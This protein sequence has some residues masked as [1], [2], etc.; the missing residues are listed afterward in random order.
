MTI[1]S[2]F[3]AL[4]ICCFKLICT[5]R[6]I[7]C[8][9]RPQWRHQQ[10]LY[11]TIPNG[12]KIY[13]WYMRKKN[14]SLVFSGSR[15]IQTI[16]STIH[17]ETRQASFPTGT[18]GPRVGIFL[19]PLDINDGFYLSYITT[20]LLS[21]MGR[22]KYFIPKRIIKG[23]IYCTLVTQKYQ[24]RIRVTKWRHITL[25][26]SPNVHRVTIKAMWR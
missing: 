2:L 1:C 17:W 5:A 24:A 3:N 11:C 19:F 20:W 8:K 16:G 6:V 9:H 18:L 10:I 13:N 14:R 12:R 23:P 21:Y 22:V 15:K 4:F 7:D 25:M 26:T